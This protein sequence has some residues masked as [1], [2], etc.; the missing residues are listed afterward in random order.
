MNV[1]GK[2][3]LICI[4][5]ACAFFFISLRLA[6]QTENVQP[7]FKQ[8]IVYIPKIKAKKAL[9]KNNTLIIDS[10]KNVIAAY[11]SMYQSLLLKAEIKDSVINFSNEGIAKRQTAI[12]DLQLHVSNYE[13][14]NLQIK[15][16]NRILII[17]NSIVSLLLFLILI[18]YLLDSRKKKSGSFQKKVRQAA[19]PEISSTDTLPQQNKIAYKLNQLERLG[20]LRDLG[21]LTEEEFILQKEI[22]LE[23]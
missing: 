20:K 2:T 4:L 9:Q 19:A 1:T 22:I 18:R 6:A 13:T 10:L 5:I 17:F 14:L 23:N 8:V 3:K 12:N 16:N 11:D 7:K 15:K 21:V